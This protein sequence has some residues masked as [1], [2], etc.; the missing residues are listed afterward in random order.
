MWRCSHQSYIPKENLLTYLAN[1]AI[2]PRFYQYSFGQVCYI[3]VSFS[4]TV[5]M[6]AT[7]MP[8]VLS[9]LVGLTAH[10]ILDSV[11]MESLARVGS[12]VML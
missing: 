5:K 7:T 6:C 2:E 3:T 12:T 10:V 8:H 9:L 1:L 11:E 4:Q